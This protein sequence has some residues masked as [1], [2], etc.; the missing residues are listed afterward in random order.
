MPTGDPPASGMSNPPESN[1]DAYRGVLVVRLEAE[2]ESLRFENRERVTVHGA[3]HLDAPNQTLTASG[4][5]VTSAMLAVE[6]LE[7]NTS[8]L[9][10]S[11]IHLLHFEIGEP[12]YHLRLQRSRDV[13]VLESRGSNPSCDIRGDDFDGP[14]P[15]TFRVEPG[16]AGAFSFAPPRDETSG[17]L[18]VC[19]GGA[20]RLAHLGVW[21][22][23]AR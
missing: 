18:P 13:L 15:V 12:P 4:E 11:N 10:V 3:Y 23:P 17:S 8:R 5:V 14:G 1:V 16:F 19:G 9:L 7:A 22:D 6:V 2:S 21:P 20:F